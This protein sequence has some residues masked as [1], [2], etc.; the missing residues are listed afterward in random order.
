MAARARQPLQSATAVVSGIVTDDTTATA[1]GAI[2]A[3][4]GYAASATFSEFVF[5]LRI[6]LCEL[7]A[8]EYFD[9][10]I[11]LAVVVWA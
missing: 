10:R 4:L 5:S 2:G 8:R 9:R 11:Q 6:S 3:A 1:V 7:V